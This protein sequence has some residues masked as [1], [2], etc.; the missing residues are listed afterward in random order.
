MDIKEIL[1]LV[2]H[3]L[4]GMVI[5]A[6]AVVRL[7]PTKADDEKLSKFLAKVHKVMALFPTLGLNPKT[8]ELM[9]ENDKR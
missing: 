4:S 9:Q 6:T 8:K 3:V 7:T 5:I 1:D 2:S